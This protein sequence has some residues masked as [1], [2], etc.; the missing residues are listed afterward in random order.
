[1]LAS[2]CKRSWQHLPGGGCAVS[3]TSSANALQGKEL[4]EMV[5]SPAGLQRL[6]L[7]HLHVSSP[8][9]CQV[10][11]FTTRSCILPTDLYLTY[12]KV[13]ILSGDFMQTRSCVWT[14]NVT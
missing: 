13:Y 14:K 2:L 5:V 8:A 3:Y 12:N 9:A 6:F 4:M 1:M 7:Y 10:R 11:C